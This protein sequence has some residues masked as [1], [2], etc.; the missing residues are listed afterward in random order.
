MSGDGDAYLTAE[1]KARVNIDRQVTAA[2]WVVQNFR[3]MN[4]YTGPGVAVREFQMA[5][6]HGESDYLLFVPIDGVPTAVG[7]LEAKPEGTTLSGVELQSRKYNEGLPRNL[8][9]PIRPLPVAYE[10]TGVETMFTCGLDPD[11]RSRPVFTFHRPETVAGW[12]RRAIE[13]PGGGTLRARLPR[14]PPV[15]TSDLREIQVR[16]IAALEESMRSNRPRALAQMASGAGKTF[17]A[18][19]ESYRLVRFADAARVLFL[20]D[21][22]NLAASDAQGAPTVL[23]PRR[24]PKVH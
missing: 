11:P 7:V 19:N 10:S 1:A 14:L 5:E 3:E 15:H 13:D 4:L 16:A 18:C 24:R 12:V 23:Y 8:K 17:M 9:S 20:V 2:G 21:R 6:G 22:A